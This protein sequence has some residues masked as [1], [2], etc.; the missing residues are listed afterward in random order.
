MQKTTGKWTSIMAIGVA[1]SS[2]PAAAQNDLG[3]FSDRQSASQMTIDLVIPFGNAATKK[4]QNA[5][6][7]QLGMAYYPRSGSTGSEYDLV[8]QREKRTSTIG[9]TLDGNSAWMLNGKPIAAPGRKAS[10]NTIETVGV[11]VGGLVLVAGGVLLYADSVFDEGPG[12]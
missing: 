5:P 11:V 12:N 1:L 10:L 2:T 4:A 3:A 6:R 8:R 9:F 7:L